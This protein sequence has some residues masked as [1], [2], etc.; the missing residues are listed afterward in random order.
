MKFY[1][2]LYMDE[3]II[4]CK[5]EVLTKLKN[6]EWQFE[7]YLIT[8]TKNEKNH[9]EFYNSVLLIQKTIPK[10]DL[11][12]VGIA[13]GYEEALEL[14]EKITQDVYDKTKGVDIRNYIL[15]TQQEYE[16]GNV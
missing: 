1:Y 10:E 3:K 8:L 7:K 15:Q 16:E 9:L 5:E 6:D 11:F 14:V 4:S 13:N 12:V 2:A